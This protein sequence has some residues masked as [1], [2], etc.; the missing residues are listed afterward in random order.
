MCVLPKPPAPPPPVQLPEPVKPIEKVAPA[1]K[2]PPPP[3]KTATYLGTAPST[4]TAV[5]S[6][7]NRFNSLRIRRQTGTTNTGLNISNG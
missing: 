3:E 7:G 6:S 4:K 5:S 2:P 1:P